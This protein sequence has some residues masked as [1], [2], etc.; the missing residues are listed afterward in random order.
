VDQ[1]IKSHQRQRVAA[2][3]ALVPVT[4]R[5]PARDRDCYERKARLYGSNLSEYLREILD[6][7]S[8]Q[9]DIKQS[10][11]DL[12]AQVDAISVQIVSL[13]NEGQGEI[14]DLLHTTSVT[15]R[16]CTQLIQDSFAQLFDAFFK[17][18]NFIEKLS[19]ALVG[20]R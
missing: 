11:T 1:K 18:Q 19:A 16:Q 7:H 2:G 20:R 4:L 10:L 5:L 17:L 13:Q 8:R 15:V 9:L 6:E 14:K 3:T 12:A